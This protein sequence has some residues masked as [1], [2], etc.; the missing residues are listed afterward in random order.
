MKRALLEDRFSQIVVGVLTTVIA[1][2]IIGMWS[3]TVSFGRL[4]ERLANWM[5]EETRTIDSATNRIDQIARDQRELER[6]VGSIEGK[7]RSN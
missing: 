7:V 4:D 2:G 5:R 1:A 6:R 3:M